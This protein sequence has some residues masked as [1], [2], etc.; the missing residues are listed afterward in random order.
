MRFIFEKTNETILIIALVLTIVA[1]LIM[2]E[3]DNTISPIMLVIAYAVLFPLGIILG[4]DKSKVEKKKK[5]RRER[6]RRR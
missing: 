6:R 5:S 3:G 4:A 2:A 1:Y